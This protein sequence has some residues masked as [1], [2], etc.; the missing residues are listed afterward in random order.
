MLRL[1]YICTGKGR[2]RTNITCEQLHILHR[3]GYTAPKMA[4]HFGCS[5]SLIYQICYQENIKL[6][7]RYSNISDNDLCQKI[8]QFHN[9]FKK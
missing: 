5:T 2:S 7:E 1:L 4:K 8:S 6:R 9:R 3:E